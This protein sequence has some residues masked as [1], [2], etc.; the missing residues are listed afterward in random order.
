MTLDDV[1]AVERVT[2]DAFYQLDIATRPADWPPPEPGQSHQTAT[3]YAEDA[4]AW[5]AA[6][7]GH[8]APLPPTPVWLPWLAQLDPSRVVFAHDNSVWEPA[9]G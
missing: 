9:R 8:A 1:A 6:G 5:R 2:A 3:A 4:L 7:D